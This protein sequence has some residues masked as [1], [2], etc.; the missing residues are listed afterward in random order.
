MAFLLKQE[1][2]GGNLHL[3]SVVVRQRLRGGMDVATSEDSFSMSDHPEEEYYGRSK[4]Y[5]LLRRLLKYGQLLVMT[6]CWLTFTYFLMANEEIEY[7]AITLSVPPGKEGLIVGINQKVIASSLC[8]RLYGPFTKTTFRFDELQSSHFESP[9]LWIK[10]QQVEE[11]NSIKIVKSILHLHLSEQHNGEWQD[12]IMVEK[13][14]EDVTLDNGKYQ[15]NFM[16]NFNGTIPLQVAY[17]FSMVSKKTGLILGLLLLLIIYIAIM[18]ELVHRTLAGVICST[19]AVGI[20]AAVHLRPTLQI[21]FNIWGNI[22]TIMLFFGASLIIELLA[23]TGLQDYLAAVSYELSNGHIWPMLHCIL[24]TS[25]L[26]SNVFDGIL[27]VL[28]IAPI[29]LRLCEIM[30]LD[31][32]PVL[33]C[34]IIAIN[35]G[36]TLT[37]ISSISN[38]L[39]SNSPFLTNHQI[40]FTEF[41]VHMLPA[42]LLTL[43]QSYIHLR[44]QF[45]DSTK[46]RNFEPFQQR[47][48]KRLIN[49][50]RRASLRMGDY[51]WDESLA[52]Q[53][54]DRRIVNLRKRLKRLGKMP[55]KPTGFEE[56]VQNL[57]ASYPI[58]NTTLVIICLLALLITLLFSI[59]SRIDQPIKI[60]KGWIAILSALLALSLSNYEDIEGMLTRIDWSTMLFFVT[61]SIIMQVLITLGLLE[62]IGLLLEHFIINVAEEH[63]LTVAILSII[64][65]SA[66]LTTF[67]DNVP[68][69]DMMMR[70]IGT[71]S[72]N[73]HINIP[74][75]PLV[76][77]LALGCTLGGNGSIVGAFANIACAGV[78]SCHGYKLTFFGYLKI[79]FFVMLGNVVVASCY[80]LTVHV[81]FR[82]H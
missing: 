50:W 56:N 81:G 66:I 30:Q 2:N 25:C 26:L 60:S 18:F 65:I 14:I 42:T 82:W 29:C 77:S 19:L 21:I 9:F 62:N 10:L 69:A 11:D 6:I 61:L 68:V 59:L 40:Q 41:I 32:T 20:I 38:N 16:S 52:R 27:L 75:M 78:A 74:I 79:G 58:K 45:L 55:E 3:S 70:I 4:Q 31:C 54:V 51:T 72:L 80:L 43:A 44:L 48:L 36:S 22:D 24:L 5:K 71:L 49:V 34:L 63:R 8:L 23:E 28:F 15:L 1:Y 17:Q 37:P 57:R 46:M 35:V 64:W 76:W 33:S 12:I 73:H 67:I 7:E 47:R 39:I 13:I 53:T